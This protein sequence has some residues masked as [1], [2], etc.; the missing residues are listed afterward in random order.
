[1]Y[2]YAYTYVTCAIPHALSDIPQQAARSPASPLQTPQYL[3]SS[4]FHSLLLTR[5]RLTPVA[6]CP[7]VPLLPVILR[8]RELWPSLLPHDDLLVNVGVSARCI[9]FLVVRCVFYTEQFSTRWCD[10]SGVFSSYVPCAVKLSCPSQVGCLL[11]L[12][13]SSSFPVIKG[14]LFHAPS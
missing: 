13:V 10:E 8:P 11:D 12:S 9:A 6:P 7:A 1:M 4:R 14:L 3:C 5:L 2:L